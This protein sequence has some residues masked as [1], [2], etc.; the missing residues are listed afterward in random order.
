MLF[1]AVEGLRAYLAHSPLAW[2]FATVA[3]Y[4]FSTWLYRVSGYIQLLHPVLI[5]VLVLSGVL[6]ATG[7]QYETYFEGAQFL[8]FF[9]GPVTVL[10]AVPLYK[11]M[12]LIR[13]ASG[14][15][16]GSLAVG[17]LIAALPA[18]AIGAWL[19][20]DAEM[21]RSLVAK[22]VTTPVAL[23]ITEK[24]G[25]I[26]AMTAV[27]VVFTGVIG[28]IMANAVFWMSRITDPRAQGLA[29]GLAAHGLGVGRAF[30]INTTAG[31]FAGL[32]MAMNALITTL[33]APALVPWLLRSLEPGAGG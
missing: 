5:A 25:G 1:D 30:Q 21:T 8:H 3:A 23:G 15:I 28:G 20:A 32:A 16:L 7:I 10:L 14:A 11:S 6:Y 26:N 22:S 24:L 29:L 4:V 27:I 19:G 33:W 9:L 12:H 13:Q 17:S 2:L 31:A 18:V